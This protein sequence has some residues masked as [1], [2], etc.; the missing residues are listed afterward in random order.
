MDIPGIL[1]DTNNDNSIVLPHISGEWKKLESG[2]SIAGKQAAYDGAALV[3]GRN[4]ALE[5]MDI[6]DPAGHASIITF[7]T[8]GRTL[9]IFAHYSEPSKDDEIK[10]HYYQHRL[11]TSD[12]HASYQTFRDGRR[13]LRNAQDYAL[14]QLYQLRDQ[15][16]GHYRKK[17]QDSKSQ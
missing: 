2:V 15:L 11:A 10:A 5:A 16:E 13:M 12:L 3:Y 9:D 1:V 4:Q 17:Y 14:E 7:A 8:N 6:A